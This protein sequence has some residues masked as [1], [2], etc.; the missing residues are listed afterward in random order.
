MEPFHQQATFLPEIVKV[1]GSRQPAVLAFRLEAQPSTV[2]NVSAT[3]PSA[4][5]TNAKLATLEPNFFALEPGNWA[6]PRQLALTPSTLANGD[7]SITFTFSSIDANYSN[8]LQTVKSTA[9]DVCYFFKPSITVDVD[10]STCGSSFDTKLY[11]FQDPIN[12]KAS[13]EFSRNIS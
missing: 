3:V 9:A 4:S 2:V 5:W 7:Y 12:L 1:G 8:M 11:M 6:Q 13:P 10:I